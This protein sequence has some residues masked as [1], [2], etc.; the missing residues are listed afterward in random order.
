MRLVWPSKY[1]EVR[2]RVIAGDGY[3]EEFGFRLGFHQGY[4]L[5]LFFYNCVR[6]SIPGASCRLS[7]GV[8]VCEDLMISIESMEE[9]LVKLKT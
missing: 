6:G 1:K 2:S 3:K 5:S 4:V 9:L 7:I 8:A